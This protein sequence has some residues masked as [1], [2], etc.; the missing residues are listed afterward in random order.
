MMFCVRFLRC[1]AVSMIPIID[2]VST[3]GTFPPSPGASCHPSPERDIPGTDPLNKKVQKV[4]PLWLL[5]ATEGKMAGHAL[6]QHG[7]RNHACRSP[8][9]R[10]CAVAELSRR[11]HAAHEGRPAE[12]DCPGTTPERQTGCLRTMPSGTN[13]R[14]RLPQ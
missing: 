10:S 2:T 7:H 5:R 8:H 1:S 6:S 14:E 4:Y 9:I 11:A 12:L 13:A 3:G